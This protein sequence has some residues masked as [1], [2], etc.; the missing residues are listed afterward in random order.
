VTLSDLSAVEGHST[1]EI[2]YATVKVHRPTSKED[3]SVPIE[4]DGPLATNERRQMLR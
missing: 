3:Y 1:Q 2:P 4:R